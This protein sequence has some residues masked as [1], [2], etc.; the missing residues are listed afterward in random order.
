[1]L[2]FIEEK[3]LIVCRVDLAGKRSISL[4]HLG[5]TTGACVPDP[6]RPSRLAR[7]DARER[8]SASAGR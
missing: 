5:W 4:P 7:I 1:M 2:A 8:R 3:G 6:S